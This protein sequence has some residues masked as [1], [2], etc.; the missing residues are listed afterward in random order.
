MLLA[1][2]NCLLWVWGVMYLDAAHVERG[3]VRALFLAIVVPTVIFGPFI[4]WSC[5]GVFAEHV[6]NWYEYAYLRPGLRNPYPL[7]WSGAAAAV[8]A[9]VI[10]WVVA[11]VITWWMLAGVKREDVETAEAG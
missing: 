9:C 11:R 7:R 10:A 5:A 6:L 8:V 1:P 4:F 3:M 2:L